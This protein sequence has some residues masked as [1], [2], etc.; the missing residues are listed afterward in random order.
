MD[1]WKYLFQICIIILAWS[2][3]MDITCSK[4]RE[5][6]IFENYFSI[7]FDKQSKTFSTA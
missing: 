5:T 7:Y 4:L 3:G 6:K 2:L 1:A